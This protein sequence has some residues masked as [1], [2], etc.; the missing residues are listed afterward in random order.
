MKDNMI[1]FEP[2]L[3][4]Y[5]DENGSHKWIHP[6]INEV[7]DLHP[8]EWCDFADYNVYRLYLT[9]DNGNTLYIIFKSEY[10]GKKCAD[11]FENEYKR[12]DMSDEE[13]SSLGTSTFVILAEDIWAPGGEQFC[14]TEFAETMYE[15]IDLCESSISFL[16]MDVV[17][18]KDGEEWSFSS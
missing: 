8:Q 15:F 12:F 4:Q 3:I 9:D 1:D 2:V 17:L 14:F 11:L 18:H 7:C 16:S 10:F 5:F 6:D 13:I